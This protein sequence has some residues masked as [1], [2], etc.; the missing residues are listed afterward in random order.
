MLCFDFSVKKK[1]LVN[2]LYEK[3]IYLLPNELAREHTRTLR[4]SIDAH[5]IFHNNKHFP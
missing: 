3:K 5:S 1:N 2:I 4:V